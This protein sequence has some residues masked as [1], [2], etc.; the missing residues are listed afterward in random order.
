MDYE[1][2]KK[3]AESLLKEIEAD[4]YRE[5]ADDWKSEAV[6]LLNEYN[7]EHNPDDTIYDLESD[8]WED[9]VKWNLDQRGWVGVKILLE[10]ID[11]NANYAYL[12]GYGN[13][14]SCDYELIDLLKY[15]IDDLKNELGEE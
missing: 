14:K 10:D 3:K 15:L 6:Y 1:E 9:L 2:M 11:N 13:G 4:K 7:Y 5:Y 12:D 8:E